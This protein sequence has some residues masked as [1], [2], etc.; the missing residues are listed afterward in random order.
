MS[1]KFDISAGYLEECSNAAPKVTVATLPS[2]VSI[3]L[4]MSTSRP[5]ASAKDRIFWDSVKPVRAVLI[6]R[7]LAPPV[8][9]S[10]AASPRLG[11]DSSATIG[12]G[13]FVTS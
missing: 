4:P 8:W 10:R 12:I 6:D 5:R 9:I 11:A 2:C 7:A 3:W 1:R 13:E